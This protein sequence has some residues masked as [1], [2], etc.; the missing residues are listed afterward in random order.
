MNWLPQMEALTDAYMAWSSC[1][2]RDLSEDVEG[3]NTW[4]Q[5]IELASMSSIVLFLQL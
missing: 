4:V 3:S 5:V 2:E 1:Q